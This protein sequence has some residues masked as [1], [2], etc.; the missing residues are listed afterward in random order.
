MSIPLAEI[1]LVPLRPA[2][3]SDAPCTLERFTNP[4]DIHNV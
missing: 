4:C 2:V 1:Q 3:R